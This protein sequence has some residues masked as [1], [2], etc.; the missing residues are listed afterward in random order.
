MTKDLNQSELTEKKKNHSEPFVFFD[1]KSSELKISPGSIEHAYFAILYDD[2][3][4]AYQIFSRIDSPRAKWGIVLLSILKG[5][6][7]QY[8]TFFQIR[9]FF[10]IDLDFL[11]KNNKISYV[12]QCL[13]ALE[14]LSGINQEIYK[15][16]ARVMIENKLYSSALKYMDKSKQIYYN[17]PELHFMLAKY[18]F[19]F[20]NYNYSYFYINEC[21]KLFP[22]YYPALLI[23]KNI[24]EIGF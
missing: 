15:F 22:N 23:K 17:D 24:E 12:E 8:P 11:L 3:D 7:T 9:N 21:L 19:D 16:T 6:M 4:S 5:F 20:K 1:N 2:L 13:G 10:E 14:L 18:Y